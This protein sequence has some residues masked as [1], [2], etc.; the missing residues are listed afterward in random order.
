MLRKPGE[1]GP[2]GA[3]QLIGFDLAVELAFDG[4]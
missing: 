1:F 2:G 4:L 3:E